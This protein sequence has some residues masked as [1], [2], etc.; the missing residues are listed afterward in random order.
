MLSEFLNPETMPFT[1]IAL[2]A[3]LA[4]FVVYFMGFFIRGAFGFGSN[5]PIVL[6]TTWVLGPH[7]AILLVLLCTFA[8][9]IHLLP[10]GL[11]TA[12]WEVTRP[13]IVGII[14][15]ITVGTWFFTKLE[16]DWLTLVMGVLITWI[17]VM[18]RF[19]LLQLLSNRI[20]L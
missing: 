6:I 20:D 2:W 4:L 3:I 5:V 9:Q 15:G 14:V 18:D 19:K 16:A 7:H 13:L 17:M 11:R 12:D 1:E 8:A 10:Q